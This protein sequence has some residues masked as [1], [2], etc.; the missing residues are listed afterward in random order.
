MLGPY[1]PSAHTTGSDSLILP[2][3]P[4][5]LSIANADGSARWSEQLGSAHDVKLTRGFIHTN[6]GERSEFKQYNGSGT[7]NVDHVARR[8][9]SAFTADKKG[10]VVFASTVSGKIDLRVWP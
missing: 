1:L 5:V 2:D 4:I 10:R 8:A 3:T 6:D 7:L 9:V